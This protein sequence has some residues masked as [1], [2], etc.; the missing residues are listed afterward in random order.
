MLQVGGDGNSYLAN[1]GTYKQI[2]FEDNISY[3]IIQH[4]STDNV[5]VIASNTFHIWDEVESLDISFG[6]ET[7]NRMNEYL[8]QF[9]SG[10]TATTL[11]LPDSVKWVNDF[12]KIESNIT[13]QCSIINN[14]GIICGV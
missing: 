13:Y 4:S 9:T 14:I 2:S 7:P 5:G 10:E 1:D 6:E 12:P 8:F 3:P 11:I